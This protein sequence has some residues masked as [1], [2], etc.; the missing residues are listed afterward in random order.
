M[1]CCHSYL[2]NKT[3]K[4]LLALSASRGLLGSRTSRSHMLDLTLFVCGN[5]SKR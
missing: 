3:E 1:A 2:P 5:S 4:V